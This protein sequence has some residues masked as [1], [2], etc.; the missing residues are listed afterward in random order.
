MSS[1][2]NADDDVSNWRSHWN[3]TISHPSQ[4]GEGNRFFYYCSQG[5]FDITGKDI[6]G[7]SYG[8]SY[9]Y[10]PFGDVGIESMATSRSDIPDV[11]YVKM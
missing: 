2:S 6:E 5:N 11:G 3:I 4:F 10:Y 9:P 7:E 8:Y 1:D